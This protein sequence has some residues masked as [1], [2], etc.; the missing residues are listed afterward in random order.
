MASQGPEGIEGFQADDQLGRTEF[1]RVQ[2]GADARHG[3]IEPQRHAQ[4]GDLLDQHRRRDAVEDGV[5]IGDVDLGKVEQVD[6]GAGERPRIAAHMAAERGVDALIG[7]PRRLGCGHAAV[8]GG[9]ARVHR[10][11]VPQIDHP[12]DAHLRPAGPLDT[13]P[14]CIRIR[15]Q[16][17]SFGMT[18]WTLA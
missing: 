11:P 18:H 10:S 8:P 2:G 9:G 7:A 5:E 16:F 4:P 15:R 3:R 1:D 13:R 12:D 17:A 6:V 14:L